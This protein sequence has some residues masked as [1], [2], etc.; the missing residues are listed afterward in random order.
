M[1]YT[2]IFEYVRPGTGSGIRFVQQS[3]FPLN[4]MDFPEIESFR[5][6]RVTC[7]GVSMPILRTEK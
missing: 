5:L 6:E 2:T 7:N 1:F 3:E 4:I